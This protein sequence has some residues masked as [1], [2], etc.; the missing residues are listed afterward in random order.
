MPYATVTHSR[1]TTMQEYRAVHAALGDHRPDGLLFSVVGQS[2]AGMHFVDVW[3]TQ[4]DADRFVAERLYPAFQRT[5]VKPNEEDMHVEFEVDV[6]A[7][8][9]VA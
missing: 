7:A 3:A 9:S 5:G 1:T 8:P 2:E 4:A 6:Y